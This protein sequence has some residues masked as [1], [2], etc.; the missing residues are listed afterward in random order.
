MNRTQ[1]GLGSMLGHSVNSL[2]HGANPEDCGNDRG[3]G[4]GGR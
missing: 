2:G 4:G 1:T 3:H